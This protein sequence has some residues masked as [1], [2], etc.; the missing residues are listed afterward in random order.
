MWI[1]FD[2]K[3]IVNDVLDRLFVIILLE[4]AVHKCKTEDIIVELLIYYF[5]IFAFYSRR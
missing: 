3:L 5:L 4:Y 1:Y 2:E